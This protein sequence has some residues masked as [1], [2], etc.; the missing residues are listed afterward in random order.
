VTGVVT[1]NLELA[2]VRTLEAM[3][4]PRFVVAMGACAIS[5]G[6]FGTSY[7]SRGGADRIVAVDL[8]VAGCPPRPWAVL[9]ALRLLL[10]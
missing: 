10:E 4:R 2:L 1:R 6:I 8:Y 7:A 9:R 3:P 5:G